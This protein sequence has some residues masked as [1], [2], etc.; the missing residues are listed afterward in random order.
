[1]PVRVR[2]DDRQQLVDGRHPERDP[3]DRPVVADRRSSATPWPPPRRPRPCRPDPQRGR[4]SRPPGRRDTPSTAPATSAST[5]VP[6]IVGS[7]ASQAG[8]TRIAASSRPGLEVRSFD[9]GPSSGPEELHPDAEPRA[10]RSHGHHAARPRPGAS[11]PAPRSSIVTRTTIPSVGGSSATRP[12]PLGLKST[13][14]AG[15]SGVVRRSAWIA[16]DAGRVTR[17][18]AGFVGG[19]WGGA[20]A[21]AF[22]GGANSSPSTPLCTAKAPRRDGGDD[23]QPRVGRPQRRVARD[24]AQPLSG[25]GAVGVRAGQVRRPR[26]WARPPAGALLRPRPPGRERRWRRAW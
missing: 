23:S 3:P 26:R 24:A 11:Q 20:P 16:R 7:L 13:V 1:M 5:R 14:L 9:V 2:V 22:D 21:W 10:G 8:S 4:R 15:C 17:T 19:T 12:T 18:G 6:P 25:Q